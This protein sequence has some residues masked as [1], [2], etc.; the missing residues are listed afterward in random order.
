MRH[1][2]V[3]GELV[4]NK[5]IESVNRA[6]K[7][8]SQVSNGRK[9]FRLLLFL[10]EIQE[11]VNLFT[12]SKLEPLVRFLKIISTSCSFIYYFSDNIVWFANMGFLKREV[13]GSSMKWKQIKNFFSLLKTVLEIVIASYTVYLKRKEEIKLRM[14]LRENDD[15]LVTAES[16]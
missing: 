11:L 12:I 2:E 6:K 15:K 8:E 9:I 5:K 1:S 14:T 16:K 4:K 10:N 13:P 7:F 3:Y